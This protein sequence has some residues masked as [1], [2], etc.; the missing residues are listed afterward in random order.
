MIALYRCGRQAEALA[1]YRSARRVL[2]EGLGTEPSHGLR[3][4]ERAILEQDVSLE[5]PARHSEPPA[6]ASTGREQP[7]S[8]G[9]GPPCPVAERRRGSARRH[10]GAAG[11]RFSRTPGI[12]RAC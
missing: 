8:A 2:M 1:V 11:G 12:W 7:L 5:P 9:A 10:S 6:I 3:R 4:L